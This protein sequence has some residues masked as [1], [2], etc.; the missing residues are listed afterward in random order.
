MPATVFTIAN[1]KGGVGKTTTAI[2]LAAALADKK[3]PTLLVDLDPQGNLTSGIGCARSKAD[4]MGKGNIPTIYDVLI[5]G[6]KA[7]EIFLAT[8]IDKLFILPSNLE[9]AGAEI[10]LVS[11]LS[12]ETRLKNARNEIAGQ[13][14]F[15]LIDCPPSLGLLTI[16]AMAAGDYL[17]IPVQCEYFA[18]EG[19]SQLLE[20]VKLVRKSLNSQL[21]LMGVV[22]TMFDSR[23]RL[24]EMVVKEVRNFFDNKVFETIIPRNVKLSESPSYGKPISEY[25]PKS[26]GGEAYERLAVE[27]VNKAGKNDNRK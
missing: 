18:L 1:Q 5:N 12:R 10:E 23:T 27:L 6:K 4:P 25:M 7:S 16:N 22:L 21:E 9:L 14:D 19:L 3:V 26:K 8:K 20:M 13:Y 11:L 15:V 17:I 2:N 24:S